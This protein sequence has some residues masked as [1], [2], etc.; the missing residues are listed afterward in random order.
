MGENSKAAAA[1][2]RKTSAKDAEN[3]RKQKELEDTYWK[4]DD[5]SVLKKQQRREEREQKRQQQ[6]EKK[7]EAKM[8]LEKETSDVTKTVIKNQKITR[9]QIEA[10]KA[11]PVKQTNSSVTSLEGNLNRLRIEGEEARSVA[12][13]IAV[14][15]S[16]AND[17]DKHPEKRLKA[18]YA[19][20]EA[21]RLKQIK[22]QNPTLRLSQIRQM[23]F[24]EW[25][26]S[27]ENPLNKL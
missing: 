6:L 15:S 1:K 12:E 27:P 19:A 26:K 2:A 13:A 8:L 23:V 5:K 11:A 16:K 21:H 22:E 4:E 10:R 3:A 17:V 18:A 25:Q 9:A 20:F 24:K 14:L 7:Q